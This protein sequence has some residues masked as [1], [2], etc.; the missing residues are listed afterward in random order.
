MTGQE[1]PSWYSDEIALAGA[2]HLD[3]LVWRAT[4]REARSQT[5]EASV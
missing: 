5:T 4:A 3:T 2:G 1:P